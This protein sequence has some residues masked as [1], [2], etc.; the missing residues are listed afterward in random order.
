MTW[1]K[2]IQTESS[3]PYFINLEKFLTEEEKTKT[4]YP[5]KEDRL[6][7]FKYAKLEDIKVVIIGQDPYHGPNQAHGL[8]FSTLD[9]K[10]PPS[11]K[12]IYKEL[13]DDLGI[14]ISKSG[15]LTSWAKQGVL[16]LNTILTVEASKPLSHKNK[17]WEIFTSKVINLLNELD[18][19]IVFILWGANARVYKNALNHPKHLV[20]EANHPSPLSA[21]RG[22]FGCKVFSKTNEYLKLNHV[23]I[24]DWQIK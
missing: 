20:L 13:K 11:L 8:A 10:L 6:N 21:H 14:E 23:N 22:F 12:N 16:L 2:F 7:A 19:A 3:K 1:E 5:K 18:Q 4:I 15:N 24:I 17:G 9:T